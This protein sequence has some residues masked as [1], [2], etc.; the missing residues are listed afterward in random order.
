MQYGRL[1]DQWNLCVYTYVCACVRMNIYMY[2]WKYVC[3]YNLKLMNCTE[4]KIYLKQNRGQFESLHIQRVNVLYC[5]LPTT[6]WA[7]FSLTDC[8]YNARIAE[9][10]STKCWHHL[11]IWFRVVKV[12]LLKTHRTCKR[13]WNFLV[14]WSFLGGFL[15]STVFH[16]GTH[17][18]T[19]LHNV[20]HHYTRYSGSCYQGYSKTHSLHLRVK[21]AK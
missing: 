8:G 15:R 14:T 5:L 9:H 20:L 7:F 16:P 21:S 3:M 18:G 13:L 17:T 2:E 6:Q 12:Q 11:L 1:K 4:H 19:D 10:V